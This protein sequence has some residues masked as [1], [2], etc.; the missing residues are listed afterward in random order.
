MK[1]FIKAGYGF[2]VGPDFGRVKADT[3]ITLDT[4]QYAKP[5]C[6]IGYIAGDPNSTLGFMR[7]KTVRVHV[8]KSAIG[9]SR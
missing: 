4:E 9:E 8:S 2:D 1:Y 7:S 6:V 5:G 3:P